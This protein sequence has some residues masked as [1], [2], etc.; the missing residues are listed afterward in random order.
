MYVKYN[1][2]TCTDDDY[3]AMMRCYRSLKAKLYNETLFLRKYR[4]VHNLLYMIVSAQLC[5][6]CIVRY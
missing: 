5:N 1:N 4:Y 6:I 3:I 2:V